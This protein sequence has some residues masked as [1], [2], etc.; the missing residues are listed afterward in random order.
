MSTVLSEEQSSIIINSKFLYDWLRTESIDF[1]IY[2][3][4]LYDGIMIDIKK[5]VPLDNIRITA[6]IK[7]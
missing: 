5:L 4:E 7:K 1:R 3:P 2:S 6:H